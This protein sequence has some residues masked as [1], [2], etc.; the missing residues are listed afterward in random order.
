[1]PVILVAA[2][3]LGSMGIV[4]VTTH[5]EHTVAEMHH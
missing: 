2:F 5:H 3:V 1:M 4:T